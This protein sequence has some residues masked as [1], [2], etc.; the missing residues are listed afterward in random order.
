MCEQD[1]KNL[2]FIIRKMYKLV[3]QIV[4]SCSIFVFLE[5]ELPNAIAETEANGTELYFQ[6]QFGIYHVYTASRQL[7]Y[8]ISE[9]INNPD[10]F[11]DYN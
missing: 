1:A 9:N 6:A 5:T 8:P 10:I 2:T 11:P 7:L 3:K 4:L